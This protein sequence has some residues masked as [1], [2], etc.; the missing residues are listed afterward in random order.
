[1]TECC[2][3]DVRTGSSLLREVTGGLIVA[4]LMTAFLSFWLWRGAWR[5]EQ[6]A[7]WVSHTYEVMAMIEG[8]LQDV[9]DTKAIAHEFALSG[10]EYPSLRLGCGL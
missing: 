3:C 5:A 10:K 9:R 8:T 6:D 2:G 4:V 7:Y 1:M